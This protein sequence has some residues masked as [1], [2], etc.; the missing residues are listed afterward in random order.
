MNSY[1]KTNSMPGSVWMIGGCAASHK[2]GS[3]QMEKQ[4]ITAKEISGMLGVSNSKAY[5]IIRELNAEL[6]ERGYLTIP[7][8]VSR[9]FYN[10]KWYGAKVS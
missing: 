7:G 6:K 5:A 2:K 3:G 4:Y 10:E 8:K 9:A 1:S